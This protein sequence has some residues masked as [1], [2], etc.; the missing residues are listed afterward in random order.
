M[1]RRDLPN[2]IVGLGKTGLSCARYFA[3][4]GQSFAVVDSRGTPP[5]L[6][7]FRAAFPQSPLFLGSFDESVLARAQR[8]IVSPG[9]ALAE[10]AVAAAIRDGAEALGDIELFA[11]A[12]RAPVVAVT[13]A[14]GKSTV[15]TLVGEMIRDAGFE[16][17]LGGNLGTPAL[18]LLAE[19]EP[20]F[21]VLELSSF[22][23]E[24]TSRLN[25]A[26]ATVLNI[27]PDHM[28]RYGGV[29]EYA[30]AKRRIYRGDGVMVINGDDYLVAAMIEPG[31]KVVRFSLNKPPQDD[32]G[33]CEHGGE[34]WL[35]KGAELLM[36]ATDLHIKGMHN[37]ANALAALALAEALGVPMASMCATL[38]RF[39]GLPHRTQWV[40]SRDG[41]TWYNDSKGTNVGATLAA[42]QGMPG[43]VVLIA[44]GLGKGQDFSPLK[45]AAI[46]KAR[47]VILLG[48][49]AAL[50]ERALAGVVPVVHVRDMDDAV[51][52]ATYLAH[53]GDTVLLSPA[54]A[55]FDMFK[56]YDHR[57]DVFTAAVRKRLA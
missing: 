39:A 3:R 50:I 45:A 4:H 25:A 28:D 37:I 36:P 53:P 33:V 22:Q 41:V 21:Y 34:L 56:G 5:G 48:Q 19:D 17:R 35:A 44:G 10:S 52:E 6:A 9:V 11:R 7:E 55:S 12:A 31:R 27:S 51:Q 54:C 49:D 20:D 2:V 38:R 40:A 47:A 32:F 42:L 24:T 13:G 46:A 18:E 16:V 23:L 57:G 43:K 26:A 30:A 1:V 29:D 15:T 8:L 14:N